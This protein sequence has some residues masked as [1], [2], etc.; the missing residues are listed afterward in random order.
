MAAVDE[1]RF[2][3]STDMERRPSTITMMLTVH[4]E[5]INLVAIRLIVTLG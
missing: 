5:S 3:T 4:H 2:L 1:A